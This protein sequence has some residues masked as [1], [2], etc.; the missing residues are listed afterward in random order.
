MWDQVL[1]VS[2]SEAELSQATEAA[3]KMLKRM[4]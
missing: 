4:R 1:E 2:D 3:L